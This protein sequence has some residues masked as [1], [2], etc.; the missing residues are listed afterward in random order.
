MVVLWISLYLVLM[1]LCGIGMS[2]TP[3]GLNVAYVLIGLGVTACFYVATFYLYTTV[4]AHPA[5]VIG[6]MI[7]SLVGV[8]C[9]SRL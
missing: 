3:D 6:M 7:I 5:T 8:F 2:Q 4:V 9:G 1:V